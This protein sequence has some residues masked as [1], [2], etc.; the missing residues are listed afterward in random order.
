MAHIT[1]DTRNKLKSS[2]FGLP[3][4]RKYPLDTKGRAIN[5][6][7]RATQMVAKGK[8]SA[9]AAAKVKAR[10]NRKLGKANNAIGTE[11]NLNAARPGINLAALAAARRRRA[12]GGVAQRLPRF[13]APAVGVTQDL[14]AAS[15]RGNPDNRNPATPYQEDSNNWKSTP[16]TQRGK[17]MNNSQGT[18]RADESGDGKSYKGQPQFGGTEAPSANKKAQP[19]FGGTENVGKSFKGQEQFGGT[20]MGNGNGRGNG[21]GGS[22]RY[23]NGSSSF[24]SMKSMIRDH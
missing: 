15:L 23:A 10:A 13:G 1:A 12:L 19:K 2:Q 17:W 6:K 4:Q 16:Y 11:Q 24:D 22:R 21:N 8:L 7:A 18:G 14:N 5:A 3:S 20:G 9:A